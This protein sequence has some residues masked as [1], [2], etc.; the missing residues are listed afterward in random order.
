MFF[1]KIRPAFTDGVIDLVPIRLYPPDSDMG[2][3]ECYDYIIAPEAKAIPLAYEMARQSGENRYFVARKKA[4][5]YM[6]GV[7]SVEV[8]SITTAGTQTLVID[9]EDAAAIKG[10]RVIIVDDVISTGESLRAMEVLCEKAGAEVVGKMAVLAE[11]DAAK[12][13]DIIVLAPLP[14]FTADGTPIDA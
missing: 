3:G 2:F 5:A 4:K 8:Q 1:R 7:F 11:G 14:L 13:E 12:R 10:K 9:A 6:Q